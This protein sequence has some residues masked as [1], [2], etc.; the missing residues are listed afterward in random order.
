LNCNRVIEL[1]NSVPLFGLEE[2]EGGV[3]VVGVQQGGGQGVAGG[4]AVYQADGGAGVG[5]GFAGVG[6]G[7]V[8]GH[9]AEGG[10]ERARGGAQRLAGGLPV[11]GGEEIASVDQGQVA[12]AAAAGI[13]LRIPAG[14]ARSAHRAAGQLEVRWGLAS[15]LAA[16]APTPATVAVGVAF[17]AHDRLLASTSR[18]ARSQ[19][20]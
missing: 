10:I 13:D 11:V 7:F 9:G 3:G 20:R 17:I 8:G 16:A 15:R 19:S 12:A 14:E 18:I 6:P 1:S 4:L 2:G 5:Q